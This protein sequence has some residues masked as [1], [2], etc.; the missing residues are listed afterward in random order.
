[1]EAGVL[2]EDAEE[3][4]EEHQEEEDRDEVE[5]EERED[6]EE[7]LINEPTNRLCDTDPISI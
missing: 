7:D 2:A 3:E 1:M 4:E 5:G 6:E